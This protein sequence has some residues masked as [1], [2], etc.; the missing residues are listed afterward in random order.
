MIAGTED[1]ATPPDLVAE[2]CAMIP[3]AQLVMMQGS[4]HIPAIDAP[5]AT[6]AAI[7]HFLRERLHD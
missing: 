7:G 1:Q 3:G 5:E 2:T 6:A 4:G